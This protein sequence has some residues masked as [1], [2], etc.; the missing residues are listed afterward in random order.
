MQNFITF[1]FTTTEAFVDTT[2]Q[3]LRVEVER[4]CNLSNRFDEFDG[5]GLFATACGRKRVDSGFQELHVADA[6]NL[7]RILECEEQ[8]RPG[9]DLGVYI[10]QKITV[11][12]D[13]S[14]IYDVTGF[15]CQ[16]VCQSALAR[17]VRAHDRMHRALLYAEIQ[18]FEY[19]F[20]AH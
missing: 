12:V 7:H 10:V 19:L 9:S 1:A 4:S 3:K 15:A 6:W 14:T 20:A 17:T 8:T 5:A 2:F 13:F 11:E 16:N 18:A